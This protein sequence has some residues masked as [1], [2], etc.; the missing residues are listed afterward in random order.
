MA[1]GFALIGGLIA[2]ARAIPPASKAVQQQK[3]DWAAKVD[4]KMK[5]GS[6]SP[7]PR[8]VSQHPDGDD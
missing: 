8:R 3:P 7:V 2:G 1:L 6:S 4:T 5:S